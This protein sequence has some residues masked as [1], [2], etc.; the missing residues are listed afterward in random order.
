L[1]YTHRID[2]A[3]L[4]GEITVD[5]RIVQLQGIAVE[6][7]SPIEPSH[8]IRT[9]KKTKQKIRMK[10]EKVN[11]EEKKVYQVFGYGGI[12]DSTPSWNELSAEQ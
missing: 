1:R 12:V 6:G 9:G 10:R 4:V 8:E 2:D 3:N 7:L 5:V 11:K